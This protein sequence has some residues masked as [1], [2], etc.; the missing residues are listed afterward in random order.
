MINDETYL[1][2]MF[3]L[4]MFSIGSWVAM[5]FSMLKGKK[6]KHGKLNWQVLCACVWGH[7]FT[8]V[9]FFMKMFHYYL[10]GSNFAELRSIYQGYAEGISFCDNQLEELLLHW[11]QQPLSILLVII[12]LVLLFQRNYTH[13][14]LFLIFFID[15]ILYVLYTQSRYDMLYIIIFMIILYKDNRD[16]ISP[17]AKKRMILGGILIVFFIVY[18]TIIRFSDSSSWSG[19]RSFALYL[20]GGVS[21]LDQGID[22]LRRNNSFCNGVN[23]IYGIYVI[24]TDLIYLLP[25][26]ESDF[27]MFL[28]NL[29]AQK[30]SFTQIGVGVWLN[31]YYSFFYDFYADGGLFAVMVESLVFGIFSSATVTKMRNN[32]D[33]LELVCK[34]LLMCIVIFMSFVRWQFVS[35]TFVF[36]YVYLFLIFHCQ[37]KFKYNQY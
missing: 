14:V 10:Q 35:P 1:V 12:F 4:L 27:T 32:K 18:A 24:I 2:I 37:I 3:G 13:P 30:E 19:L 36:G 6:N 11:I 16:I 7:L 28:Y 8:T 26:Q 9:Y 33:D 22:S 29:H 25:I 23:F 20:G 31:A 5:P 34:G 15:E 21:L 17:T